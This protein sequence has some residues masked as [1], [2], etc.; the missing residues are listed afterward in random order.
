MLNF[1]LKKVFSKS[2]NKIVILLMVVITIITSILTINRVEYVDGNGN[3]SVGFTAAKN[4]R[5]AR[6]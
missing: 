1:E 6:N 3:H 2:R 5:D 4:L